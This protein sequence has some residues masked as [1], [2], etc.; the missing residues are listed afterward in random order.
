MNLG[1][2]AEIAIQFRIK[3]NWKTYDKDLHNLKNGK[4]LIR[5]K[6]TGCIK[7]TF[8]LH[9]INKLIT[10]SSSCTSFY[11]LYYKILN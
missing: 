10:F 1:A 11:S 4:E 3:Q 5:Q 7:I 6:I 9:Q 2:Y 8:F